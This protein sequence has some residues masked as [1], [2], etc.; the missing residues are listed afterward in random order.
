M[1]R[2]IENFSDLPWDI[3]GAIHIMKRLLPELRADLIVTDGHIEALLKSPYSKHVFVLDDNLLV[4]YAELHWWNTATGKGGYIENVVVTAEHRGQKVGTMLLTNLLDHAKQI[5][6]QE[7]HLHT[8]TWRKAAI[9]LYKSLGFLQK[10]T[11]VQVKT[12]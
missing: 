4:G 7:V 5:G 10:D 12:L 8:G 9:G 3:D 2:L 1:Y 6:V 11:T